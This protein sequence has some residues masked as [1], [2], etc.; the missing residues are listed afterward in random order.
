MNRFRYDAALTF[1]ETPVPRGVLGRAATVE[2]G[3]TDCR[4]SAGT[5]STGHVLGVQGYVEVDDPDAARMAAGIIRTLLP[6]LEKTGVAT[7]DEVDI[8]TL[9]ERV[10]RDCAQHNAIFKP[11]TLVSA[12]ARVT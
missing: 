10:A 1:D 7:P 11:P 2:S 3:R 12:W 9:E 4:G 5:G 8:E 6:V